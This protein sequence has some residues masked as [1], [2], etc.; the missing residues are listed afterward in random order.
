M[1]RLLTAFTLLWLVQSFVI[2]N[3]IYTWTDDNGVVHYGDRPPTNVEAEQISIQGRREEPVE[4]ETA[5]LPGQWFGTST[6]GGEVRM[7]LTDNGSITFIQTRS[8][9]SVFNYQG[10]WSYE[11]N[12]LSVI[13]EFSQS[14]PA[15]GDFTR[16][17]EPRQFLYNIIGFDAETPNMELIIG[18]ERFIVSKTGG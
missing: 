9:N 15:N 4:V 10:I 18:D 17:V 7:T 13:T 1:T 11:T 16:S 8:D 5:I 12:A 14:A 3:E 2:A 6:D